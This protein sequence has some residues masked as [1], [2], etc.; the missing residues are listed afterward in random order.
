MIVH[1]RDL[2]AFECDVCGKL[3]EIPRS[4]GR[5]SEL[6]ELIEYK[7]RLAESHKHCKPRAK[8]GAEVKG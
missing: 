3:Y 5:E 1:R 6:N 8:N 7:R 2:Q 4:R